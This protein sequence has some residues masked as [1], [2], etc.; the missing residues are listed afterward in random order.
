MDKTAVNTD[1]KMPFWKQVGFGIGDFGNNFIWT[2]VGSYLMFFYTDVFGIPLAAVSTLMLVARAWDAIN[3]PIIGSLADRTRSKWGRYR[4]WVL[5]MAFPTAIVLVLTFW[6]RPGWS[7]TSKIVYMYI[8]YAVLVFC[9]TGVNIPY[10]AMTSVLTQNTDE[11]A[12]L[13]TMRLTLADI[14]ISGIGIITLPLVDFFGKGDQVFGFKATAMLFVCIFVVC[15]AIVFSSCRE[16]VPPP[17]KKKYP[18]GVQLRSVMKNGPF[19][20]AF[21]GQ[22]LWGFYIHGR[23]SIYV[24]YFKYVCGNEG[25]LSMYNLVGLV[26]MAAGCYLFRAW[27]RKNGNKGRVT[28]YACIIAGVAMIAMKFTSPLDSPVPFYI[29]CVV[30]QF[31][32]GVLDS[33]IYGVIPDTVE[34]GELK[35]GVRNDGFLSAFIS[36]GNKF[37]IALGSAGVSAFLAALGYQANVEQTPIVVSAIDHLFSTVPGVLSVFCG[38]IFLFYKVDRK[39][40][41]E[42]LANLKLRAEQTENTAE[43][44]VEN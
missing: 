29:L 39:A 9:Y 28:A 43:G 24:Y 6:A 5:F 7:E 1:V 17:K 35:T 3:D 14:A 22:L 19:I 44:A 30:S 23:V 36:L 10:S 26:P 25:L 31:F 27:Y 18:L 40:F 21:C 15:Q 4:P 20:I 42:I 16:V 37:G 11:R 41:N 13:S 34:Y 12:K 2:F 8:T 38:V 33:G 32:L